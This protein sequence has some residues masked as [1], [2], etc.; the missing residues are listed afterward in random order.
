VSAAPTPGAGSPL[1][2]LGGLFDRVFVVTLARARDRQARM[3]ERLAGVPY[4]FLEGAD[5]AAFRVEDLVR[6]G[7]YDPARARAVDRYDR[8]LRPGQLG[9]ALSHRQVY[10]ETA[11]NGWRRVLVLEDDVLPRLDD[12]AALPAAVA[13]LPPDWDLAYLGYGNLRTVTA[14]D[15][16]KQALYLAGAALRLM[17]WRPSQVLRFHPRPFSAHLDVAGLHHG[18]Y[19]YAISAAGA[20]KLL[21]AQTPV[22]YVADQLFVQLV[23]A[24][25]LRAFV[26]KPRFFDHEDAPPGEPRSFVRAG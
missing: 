22:A 7:T 5:A 13:E 11:R 24:G 8:E 14:R 15:R 19:A 26:T 17:K 1:A 16:A 18:T 20:R 9:C 6:D 21:E 12:L 4:R 3:R 23:L 25:K 10:E 2:A